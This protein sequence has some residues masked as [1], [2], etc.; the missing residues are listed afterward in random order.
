MSM[1]LDQPNELR[2]V[3]M[4]GF[5][6]VGRIAR[7]LLPILAV[8]LAVGLLPAQDALAQDGVVAGRV[9]DHEGN[10]I[11]GARVL[12]ISPER[13]DQR[14]LRV[15]EN[16]EFMGRGFRPENY[17]IRAEAD[18]YGPIEQE[19][20]VSLGMNTVD[21][22][23][24]PGNMRPD[25]DYE[26]LNEL[27]D[28]GFQAYEAAAVS[29]SEE[30]WAVAESSL[31]EL[32]EGIEDL[33]GEDVAL[34]RL[35]AL[36]ILGVSQLS[37]QKVDA[38]IATFDTLLEAD[39]DNLAGHTWIGQGYTR[40]GEYEKASEHLSRA[41][42]LAPDDPDVQYNAG[43]VLLQIGEIEAGIVAMERALE[44]RPQFP[45]ARK[46]LGYAYLRTEEY[47][48]AIEML[49]GYLEMEPEAADRAEIEQMLEALRAQIQQQGG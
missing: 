5:D 33:E 37:L 41:A 6:T 44:L 14:E 31:V 16:G 32:L 11:A 9:T 17:I 26:G 30:D 49:E 38:S 47:E 34:I 20:R 24:P 39:P 46:N 23:L 10:P 15:D 29:G 13:G 2:E 18:G 25:V 3:L 1:S 42:E 36:Q 19:M 8:G 48:K 27:Y 43:A 12:V 40:K 35:S 7:R 4:R 22:V 45:V 28:K 21:F